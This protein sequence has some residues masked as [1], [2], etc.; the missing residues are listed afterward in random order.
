MTP[1]IPTNLSAGEIEALINAAR[2]EGFVAGY[3]AGSEEA[4]YIMPAPMLDAF[5]KAHEDRSVSETTRTEDVIALYIAMKAHI[6][7]EGEAVNE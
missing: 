6:I 2:D 4:P 1:L 3:K 5:W 7:P